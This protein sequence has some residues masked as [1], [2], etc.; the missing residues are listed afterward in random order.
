MQPQDT[1]HSV[2]P[3]IQLT[4]ND[5]DRFWGKVSKSHSCWEWRA[6]ID[7]DG[8]GRLQVQGSNLKSHRISFQIHKGDIPHEMCVCHTCDNRK[9]V[10]PEH[11]FLGT[12][13]D[14][15]KD[16]CEKG[17]TPRGEDVWCAKLTWSDV[18]KI[19]ERLSRGESGRSLAK[20]LRVNVGVISKIKNNKIWR[21]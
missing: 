5:I 20:E 17:R 6:C 12:N 19:R 8:Y 21:I 14:N 16:R 10:N 4:E 15:V 2:A 1:A 18:A 13:T 11:L 3:S 9:C 7:S